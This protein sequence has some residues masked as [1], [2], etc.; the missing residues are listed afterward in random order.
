M[1]HPGIHPHLQA[2]QVA[3]PQGDLLRRDP[4][5]PV[6]PHQQGRHADARHP[7]GGVLAAAV[8]THQQAEDLHH[9]AAIAGPAGQLVV[10]IGHARLDTAAI[11]V[12]LFHALGDQCARHPQRHGPGGARQAGG[13]DHPGNPAHRVADRIEQHQPFHPFGLFQGVA[14][15]EIAAQR[16]ADQDRP[17]DPQ[18][19]EQQTQHLAHA[20]LGVRAGRRAGEAETG[21]VEADHPV[22]GRKGLHPAVP[23]MQRGHHA[24]HHHHCRLVGVTLVAVVHRK[25]IQLHIARAAGRMAITGLERGQRQFAEAQ[26][27]DAAGQ[28]RR[29]GGT[30]SGHDI[31]LVNRRQTRGLESFGPTSITARKKQPMSPTE[32]RDDAARRSG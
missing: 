28:G 31:L 14:P 19:I 20:L 29:Q 1:P 30:G 7:L 17:L 23:G 8:Q 24:V 27:G 3:L 26:A 5:V 16:V 21:Q 15:G 2:R 13:G 10:A 12:D 6:A 9:G 32:G 25:A 11:S 22:M 18:V 4:A